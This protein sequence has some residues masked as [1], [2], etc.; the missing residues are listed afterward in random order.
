MT[1]RSIVAFGLVVV[2]AFLSPLLL[3]TSVRT[4]R[5]LA[6]LAP[7]VTITAG[8]GDV[9]VALL[10]LRASGIAPSSIGWTLRALAQAV[11]WSAVAWI[12]WGVVLGLL[13][14]VRPEYSV[15]VTSLR[16]IPVFYLFV[17]VPEELLFRGYIL[18]WLRRF[19]QGKASGNW[20]ALWA[21]LVSS[22]LFALFHIPQRLL[23]ARMTWN[24]DLLM[25]LAGVFFSSL[26]LAWLF[27]RSDNVWWVG[28]YHGGQ[29]APLLSLGPGDVFTGIGVAVV[30]LLLTEV[31]RKR[32]M[33]TARRLPPCA[34]S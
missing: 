22:L 29:D 5:I 11:V 10:A 19:F 6:P 32:P 8:V 17:G 12:L 31:M 16:S 30:Y 23:V 28:L 34:S 9:I 3:F 25:N 14:L 7:W 1:R 18:T 21:A 24:V 4:F 20:A 27:L 26:F 33:G 13:I 15:G 2:Y